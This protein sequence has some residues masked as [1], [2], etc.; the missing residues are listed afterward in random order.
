MWRE[1]GAAESKLRLSRKSSSSADPWAL[2]SL[3]L[4]PDVSGFLLGGGGP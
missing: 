3:C 2:Y 1:Q 4:H